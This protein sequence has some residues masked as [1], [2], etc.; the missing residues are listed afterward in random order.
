[1]VARNG[2]LVNEFAPECLDTKDC[3]L[4]DLLVFLPLLIIMGAFMFFAS[5]RQKKAM[6]ATIDLHNSLQVGD[7]ITDDDTDAEDEY[8]DLEDSGDELGARSSATEI[9]DRP[10]TKE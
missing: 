1:M 3:L 2:T 6:Q 5:R 7:R 10:N 8:D 9:S 4:M